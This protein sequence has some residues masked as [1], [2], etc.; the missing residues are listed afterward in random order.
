MDVP[1]AEY[2]RGMV[3]F[4]S[5]M[6]LNCTVRNESGIVERADLAQLRKTGGDVT[7][8]ARMYLRFSQKPENGAAPTF[9]FRLCGI[10]NVDQ[11]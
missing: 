11:A 7:A 6:R 4:D 5:G 1:R 8:D 10:D 2:Q 9:C 3:T